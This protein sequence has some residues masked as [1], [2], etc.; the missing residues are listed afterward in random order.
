[1]SSVA[2]LCVETID[3]RKTQPDGEKNG[4][5]MALGQGSV[6]KGGEHADNL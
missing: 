6:M 4:S 3:S 2:F 5:E 1:M